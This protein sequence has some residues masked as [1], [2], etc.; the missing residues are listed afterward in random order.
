MMIRKNQG[1]FV[2]K[3]ILFAA[4]YLLIVPKIIFSQSVDGGQ[5]GAFLRMGVGAR[6][7]GMGRT[8]AAIANDASTAFWNPAGLG[9]LNVKELMGTYSVLSMDRQHN[10]T[11]VALP[12]RSLGTIGIS[13]INLSVGDIEGRDLFGRITDMYSNSENAYFLSWGVALNQALYLGVTAK[14]ITHTLESYHSSG[15]GFDMGLL[16]KLTEGINIGLSVQ[17]VST[18]V[19]WDTD[20]ETNE[21]YPL[22]ARIGA[23]YFPVNIP[24]TVGF[25]IEKVQNMKVTL[26]TGAEINLYQGFGFRLGI[27][28]GKFGTGALISVPLRNMNFQTDY[29]FTQDPI[30]KTY[31]HR[32]ANSLKFAPYEN[33]FHARKDPNPEK[34]NGTLS[35]MTPAPDARVIKVLED[36]PHLV[37]INASYGDGVEQG[38]IF[39]VFRSE[40]LVED[41]SDAKRMLIGTVKVI[42]MENRVSAV[43]VEWMKEGYLIQ[44]NDILVRQK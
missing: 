39:E 3:S 4:L 16:Y 23:A 9:R 8:F 26:H 7:I 43:R 38:M 6:A 30:D 13:W 24:I 1:K 14:Y 12:I 15:Y 11:A 20:A 19:K 32:F 17:D 31:I 5:P 28:N 36:Y 41:K 40:S 42:K 33:Y 10:Y 2:K 25:D 34:L 35:L 18:R 44:L 21:T 29:S 22:A 37:L 27:D